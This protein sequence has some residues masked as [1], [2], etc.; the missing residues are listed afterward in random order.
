ML[1]GLHVIFLKVFTVPVPIKIFNKSHE[2]IMG[3]HVK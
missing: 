1:F 2:V 3:D